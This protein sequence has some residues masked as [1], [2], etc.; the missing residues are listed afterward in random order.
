MP[1]DRTLTN[2]ALRATIASLEAQATQVGVDA[3]KRL[4]AARTLRR[5]S[6]GR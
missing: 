5:E 3:L 2:T 6:A 1:A 4:L